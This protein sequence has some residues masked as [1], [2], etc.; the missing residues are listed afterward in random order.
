[1]AEQLRALPAGAYTLVDDDIASGF[2][3]AQVKSLLPSEV[4]VRRVVSLLRDGPVPAVEHPVLDVVDLRDLM[5][6]ATDAGLVVQLPD[7]TAARAPY[8]LPYVST[9]SR[10]KLPPSAEWDFSLAVWK[11]NFEFFAS[12]ARNVTVRDA[13]P[14]TAALLRYV[15]FDQEQTLREVCAWHLRQLSDLPF[16]Q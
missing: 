1:V 6:G 7:G 9:V 5:L 14:A 10:A 13:D 15:G 16:V 8:A 3:M 4:R 11:L 12:A 2:T